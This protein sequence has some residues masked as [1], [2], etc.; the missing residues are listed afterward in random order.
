MLTCTDTPGLDEG[1]KT[2]VQQ[3][4]DQL[5]MTLED[6]CSSKD[7][8][9]TQRFGKLLLA[10]ATLKSIG[11]EAIQEVEMRKLVAGASLNDEMFEAMCA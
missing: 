4:Q 2:Q 7:V 6:Y 11:Q 9:N 3:I 5:L 1:V 10:V 8:S